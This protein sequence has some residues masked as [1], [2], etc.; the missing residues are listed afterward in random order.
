M[1]DMIRKLAMQAAEKEG[2][3]AEVWQTTFTEEFAKL[4]IRETVEIA[5]KEANKQSLNGAFVAVGSAKTIAHNIKE[6]F[7]VAL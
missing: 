3:G 7:G 5:L 4:L 6:H 2:W 1:N